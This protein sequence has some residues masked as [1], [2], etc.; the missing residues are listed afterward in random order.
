MMLADSKV[1]EDEK[2][3][4]D[5]VVKGFYFA[6]GKCFGLKKVYEYIAD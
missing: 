4:S 1:V 5:M 3:R 6:I 2:Y